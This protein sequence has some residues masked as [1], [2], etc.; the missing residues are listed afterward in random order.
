MKKLIL[1]AALLSAANSFADELHNF[2]EIKAAVITGKTIHIAIDF[3]KCSTPNK[4]LTQ[5][6][7]VGVFTPNA[8]AV[9]ADYMATSLTHFTLNNPQAPGKPIYEFV[10]YT[11]TNKNYVNLTTQALDAVN[12]TPVAD[13]FSF[14]CEIES[15]A[16]I[17]T[18]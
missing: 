14:N 6:M 11:I 15:G 4:D 13:S 10:R 18:S 2:D 16:K 9:V 8:I 12:Y 3:S 17:Y 7:I 5:S 1:V